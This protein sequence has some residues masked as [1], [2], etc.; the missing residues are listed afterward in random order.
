MSRN[1]IDWLTGTCHESPCTRIT[2]THTPC[3]SGSHTRGRLV[4]T[5]SKWIQIGPGLNFL[6]LPRPIAPCKVEWNMLSF[7]AI[8][9]AYTLCRP[10]RMLELRIGN[11]RWNRIR[12][13]YVFNAD[14]YRSCVGLRWYC[15]ETAQPIVKLSSLPAVAPWFYFSEVKT[16]NFFP[17]FQ[18]KHPKRGR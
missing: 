18:W 7:G 12:V 10:A 11:F 16:P 15:V 9:L 14:C 17:E 2:S 8:E 1:P 4:P 3:D 13:V 6:A 5:Q